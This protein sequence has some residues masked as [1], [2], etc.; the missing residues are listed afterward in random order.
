M[1]VL[2][3]FVSLFMVFV[4]PISNYLG[5]SQSK[6]EGVFTE[7]EKITK[8]ARVYEEYKEGKNDIILSD[9]DNLEEAIE[10]AISLGGEECTIWLHEGTYN[11]SGTVELD[12]V[13]N[14]SVKAFPNEKASVT[15]VKEISGWSETTVNGVKAWKTAADKNDKFTTLFKGDQKLSVTRYPESGYFLVKEADSSKALFTKE[16][17]PWDYTRGDT[18][19][20]SKSDIGLSSFYNVE[21]VQYKLMHYWYCENSTLTSYENGR[22]SVKQPCSMIIE[23]NDRFYFENVFEA[24]DKPGEWY[25]DTKENVIYYIPQDGD[26]IAN[27]VL[28][29]PETDML[30]NIKNCENINFSGVTFKNTDWSYLK[31]DPSIGW[32]SEYG[33]IFPQG[34]LECAGV[35]DITKSEEINFRSCDF[36]NIG[37]TGIRFYKQVKNCEITGCKFKEIGGNVI[38][39]DGYNTADENMMTKNINVTDNLIESYGRTF[40]SGIGVILTHAQDCKISHNEIHDGYYTAISCG[41]VWGYTEHTTDNIEISDNLIYDIG[42]GWLSDMGGIYTLGIQ[43]NT[44][45]THN[46]IYNVAADPS[47]GGY[48]GW[49][50]YLDEGSS[51]ITVYQNL[52]Y[53]C[54]SDSFHQHYG[55]NNNV[56]NNIFALSAEG[57]IRNTRKEDHNELN[58][59]K[60]IIL[61]DKTN[62]YTQ[63]QQGKFKDGGNL[64]WDITNGKNVVSSSSSDKK[65]KHRLYKPVMEKMGYY[66]DAVFAD[67]LFRDAENFDFTLADNSPAITQLGFEVWNYNTAGT[68]TDFN[69]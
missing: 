20:Y 35:F 11:I 54:G 59:T 47:E 25:H 55:E 26:E 24:L 18:A 43:P 6:T 14:L 45:L 5:L 41:W 56:T 62:T 4:I 69:K 9:G 29:A 52:V 21:D 68:V 48:G 7:P 67:P 16:N 58:L 38:F 49:G 32:V 34:N 15:A 36:L 51:Y 46:K 22:I 23:E 17:T 39:I 65:F 30:F 33:L 27:T 50:I 66:N 10:K 60:N 3:F 8:T 19:F 63:T 53:D 37:S 44:I 42:Q 57:Q 2:R 13:K 12:G 1:E 28:S 40:P 31:S 61:T 64:Y